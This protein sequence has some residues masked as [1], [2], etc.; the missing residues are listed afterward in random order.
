MPGRKTAVKLIPYRS[1]PVF[2]RR[3][4]T[5]VFLIMERARKNS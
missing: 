1:F 2:S 5:T 3:H 4:Y